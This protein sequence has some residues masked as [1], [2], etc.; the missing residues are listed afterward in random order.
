[1]NKQCSWWIK[2]HHTKQL[3][4]HKKESFRVKLLF[5]VVILFPHLLKLI[6]APLSTVRITMLLLYKYRNPKITELN[7]N[8]ITLLTAFGQRWDWNTY[9]FKLESKKFYHLNNNENPNKFFL[10]ITESMKII[11]LP[12]LNSHHFE[13]KLES[14]TKSAFRI[15]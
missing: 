10:I 4:M 7:H 6:F 11:L 1:M 8:Y 15:Q 5:K 13:K 9:F 3:T 12:V 14:T 2:G